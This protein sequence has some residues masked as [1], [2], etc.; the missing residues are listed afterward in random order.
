METDSLTQL[1]QS[2]ITTTENG[3]KALTTSGSCCL[4]FFV[5]ITRNAN[6][7][8]YIDTFDK[9]LIEDR[10]TAIKLLMNMRDVRSGKGEKLIPIVI[11]F[12]IKLSYPADV[13]KAVLEKMVEYGYWKDL[14]KIIEIEARYNM[15]I[16]KKTKVSPTSIEVTMFANQL[17]IDYKLLLDAESNP[18][19]DNKKV[20]ISLCAKW[21]PS[22]KTHYDHH[23]MFAAKNISTLM[24]MTPKEYRVMLSKLRSHLNI[25]EMLMCGQR[26][27]EIDFSKL[28][29]IAAMKMKK[30]FKRDTNAAGVESESRKR[31]NLTYSQYLT[32][33]AKGK[34]K[35]NVKGVHPHEI[36]AG[37]LDNPDAEIDELAEAQW[38]TIKQSIMNKNIFRDCTA[39]VDVSGSM[40]G[41][42]MAVAISLG[43]LL[44]E[45]TTGPFYGRVI[46]FHETP[47]WHQL[48][49]SNLKEQVACMANMSWGG[50]TN[51]R[52]CYDLILS[53]AINAKLLQSEM[54]KTLFIFS[55]MQF[56]QAIGGKY[57]STL[58][59]AKR[60]FEEAGYKLP[61]IVFW[62]LRT[63]DSKSLPCSKDENG[64]TMLSGFSAELL[65]CLLNGDEMTPFKMMMHVLEPYV[66]PDVVTNYTGV[67]N[68]LT[69]TNLTH[70]EAAV[71][72][73]ATKKAFLPPINDGSKAVD[74]QNTG[75]YGSGTAHWE[76]PNPASDFFE[77]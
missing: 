18:L 36:V 32:D 31:L 38:N 26:F 55:D 19:P 14:L 73:S 23:P 16:S 47:T 43:I 37:Y 4:D 34:T 11:L 10:E 74:T 7:K 30:A 8:D 66:V 20:S 41:Q 69:D 49:G 22:E 52:A 29:S 15:E 24:A 44:S 39:V 75:N 54:V 3:D 21:A 65:K 45:C 64:V 5:R 62:N 71:T 2:N 53:N 68:Q 67:K 72:K 51:L 9:A 63:S 28:P 58:E 57:E 50:S 56:D 59:Y 42:P 46:T 27:D 48:V 70:L 77:I 13:Y 40:S 61:N 60:T 1:T 76:N 33:L 35:V 25:L 12:Y 17:A 6:F